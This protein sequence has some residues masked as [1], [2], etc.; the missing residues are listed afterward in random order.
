M[1]ITLS[2][3]NNLNTDHL[4]WYQFLFARKPISGK[5]FAR[6]SSFP[7]HPFAGFSM[8]GVLKRMLSM[9]LCSQMCLCVCVHVRVYGSSITYLYINLLQRLFVQSTNGMQLTHSQI[10]F[11]RHVASSNPHSHTHTHTYASV[12][13]LFVNMAMLRFSI[14]IF[15]FEACQ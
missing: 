13:R 12:L 9:I 4:L 3:I 5:L 6:R 2:C 7:T 8:Q 1:I 15:I 14:K 11:R 10:D